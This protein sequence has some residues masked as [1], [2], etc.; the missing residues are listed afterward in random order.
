MKV[1]APGVIRSTIAKKRLNFCTQLF[2]IERKIKDK[3]ATER[4]QV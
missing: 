4:L 1:A 3:D 2:A